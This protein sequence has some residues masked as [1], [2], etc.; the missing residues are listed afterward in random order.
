MA[1]NVDKAMM[2]RFVHRVFRKSDNIGS[3]TVKSLRMEFLEHV[4]LEKLDDDQREVFKK[5][6]H[7]VYIFYSNQSQEKN[8]DD[9]E[10]SVEDS[11]SDTSDA[12]ASTSFVSSNQ[13]KRKHGTDSNKGSSNE[14]PTNLGDIHD[15]KILDNNNDLSEEQCEEQREAN[16]SGKEAMDKE[17][18]DQIK[19][20]S[21]GKSSQKQNGKSAL[22]RIKSKDKEETKRSSSKK[23]KI[24]QDN[25]I[26]SEIVHFG[27]N[28]ETRQ[29]KSTLK[30]KKVLEET[31]QD[32]KV[33][34]ETGK[35]SGVVRN[36]NISKTKEILEESDEDEESMESNHDSDDEINKWTQGAGKKNGP[37]ADQCKVKGVSSYEKKKKSSPP[38]ADSVRLKNFKRYVQTCGLRKNYVKLFAECNS[39]SQKEK[40]LERVLRKDTGFQGRITLVMCKEFKQAKEE[41]D[42]VAELDCSNIISTDSGR[43]PTRSSRIISD[44]KPTHST[45]SNSDPS[46]KLF[47]RLQGVVDSDASNSEDEQNGGKNKRNT[48]PYKK[49]CQGN[50][51]KRLRIDSSSD[52]DWE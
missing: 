1:K 7:D 46:P 25:Y 19:T 28:E 16:I 41:A 27:I 11:Q 32:S 24:S 5:T 34:N 31:F 14:Y 9:K 30:R 36:S 26:D 8:G 40:I 17:N 23:R 42:E 10:S 33:S 22:N 44:R 2:K 50:S 18:I 39:M 6:V 12:T 20:V 37:K 3:L 4:G 38:S 15:D 51:R 35:D 43:R 47:S 13:K 21:C 48:S 29:D 52:D 49:N 45:I